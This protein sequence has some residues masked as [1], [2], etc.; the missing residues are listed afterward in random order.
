MN[1]FK[2]GTDSHI[3]YEILADGQ[4]HNGIEIARRGKPGCV[5]WAYRSRISCDMNPKLHLAGQNINSRLGKNR[6]A[7]Y[8]LE[9]VC[10]PLSH[11][12]LVLI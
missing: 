4:W 7:E 6:M 1:P 5:N 10:D 11:G 12:Q 9:Y 2:T 8:R 3:I